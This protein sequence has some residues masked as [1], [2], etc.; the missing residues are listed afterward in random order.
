[1]TRQ[2]N[3]IRK[4]DEKLGSL[5]LATMEVKKTQGEIAELEDK[6][7][8]YRYDRLDEANKKGVQIRS[9]LES[10]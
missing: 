7:R 1:M 4:V 9:T 2:G 6:I 8:R 5:H 10:N 3:N